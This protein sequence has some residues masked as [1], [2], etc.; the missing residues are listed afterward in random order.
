MCVCVFVCS[1]LAVIG[2]FQY[3]CSFWII[4]GAVCGSEE[5]AQFATLHCPL[6]SVLSKADSA[7]EHPAQRLSFTS[8]LP[9]A[10]HSSPWGWE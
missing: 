6:L 5:S 10:T 1:D 9:V 3:L 7:L 4:A 8:S 2:Q